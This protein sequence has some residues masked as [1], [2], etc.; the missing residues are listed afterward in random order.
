VELLLYGFL[1]VFFLVDCFLIADNGCFIG[2]DVAVMVPLI[3]FDR[4]TGGMSFF[5]GVLGLTTD[6]RTSLFGLSSLATIY[7]RFDICQGTELY[8]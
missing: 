6:S 3:K 5:V 4:G 1:Q 8:L 2:L 7:I